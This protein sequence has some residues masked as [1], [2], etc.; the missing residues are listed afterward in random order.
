[1]TPQAGKAPLNHTGVLIVNWLGHHCKERVSVS[2][3][4]SLV[5]T[6]RLEPEP[7]PGPLPSSHHHSLRHVEAR[8]HNGHKVR[9]AGL[10]I[11]IRLHC[12]IARIIMRDRKVDAGCL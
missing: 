4:P 11:Y 9:N 10:P 1:M 8:S 6:T 7:S 3:Q 2:T 12:L 5:V